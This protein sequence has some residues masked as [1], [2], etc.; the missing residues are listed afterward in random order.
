M[1]ASR[2]LS[3]LMLL[4][5]RG[6]LTAE[7]LAHEFKVSI[8]TIYRDVD[9]LSASG[10]PIFSDRGPGGGFELLGGYQTKLT[11]LALGEAEA[12]FMIGLPDQAK[13]LGLGDA[14]TEAR[15]KL[16]AAL[17]KS[18]HE[19]AER[20]SARFY[21]DPID[22]YQT[23]ES[24]AHLPELTRAV[25]DQ[26]WIK[27]RYQSWVRTHT[28][29]IAPLGLVQKAGA[30]YLVALGEKKIRLFKVSNILE[31]TV[32]E[33]TFE[34]P[35]HFNLRDYWSTE[36]KRFE[37]QLRPNVALLHVSAL[38]QSRLAR[39]GAYAATAIRE[40]A[41]S[42]LTGWVNL[43]LPIENIDQAALLL[44]GLGPEVEVIEPESLRHRLQQLAAQIV[45][46]QRKIA[47][48]K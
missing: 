14:S 43:K 7:A 2:L 10:I 40:A 41:P 44:L 33:T 3:I 28:W 45:Y 13:E 23:S 27:M 25:L 17:P 21:L 20:I 26:H 46:R 36:L 15:K 42:N 39:L 16:L 5:L 18:W 35:I 29:S 38:G 30:W 19:G 22:W 4:Q 12:L 34:R 32:L 9:E 11:G 47:R 31:H 24:V 1:R 8:R 37:S 6:R 48:K